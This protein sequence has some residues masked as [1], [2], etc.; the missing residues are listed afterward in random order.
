[1]AS[2]FVDEKISGADDLSVITRSSL[3]HDFTFNDF[4]TSVY[5]APDSG[6]QALVD[7]F[8]LWADSTTGIPYIE[9]TTAYFL[10]LD[11]SNPIVAIA[12]D[13]ND[14]NP[15]GPQFIPLSGTNLSYRPTNFESDA[16]LDYKFVVGGNW[17]LDPLNPH[18]CSGGFGPNS[19]LSMLA[20]RQPMEILNYEIPMGHMNTHAYTD[21][22]QG[23][24]RS[25]R[26]YTPPGYDGSESRYRN[27]YFLDGGEYLELGYAK[28][29]LDYMIF[30][31]L[32]PPVIAIFVDPSNRDVEYRY[33]LQFMD[34]FVQ[35]LVPW[36][37]SKYRTM[38]KA[39]D[40]AIVGVSLGGLTSL[41]FTL[42]HPQTFGNCGA[43]SPAIQLGDMIEQYQNSPVLPVKIYMDAGTY[44]ATI[45]NSATDLEQIFGENVWNYK[46]RVWHEGHSWGS[47]RAHVDE[48][49]AYFWPLVTTGVD[50][51][52]E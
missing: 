20:Y 43:Y 14:W 47:W 5:Q 3:Q 27:I 25:V 19:E 15:E 46:W 44:E 35:E 50:N 32:I 29:I 22:T 21:S 37:D 11:D 13:F 36:V 10:Y 4:I 6:K 38:A 8:V 30:N 41:L 23:K 12:G 2:E 18:T 49:L 17:I 31:E 39:S 51:R 24:T 42:H 33:D 48:S 1:M 26:V 40:R 16:R 7:A 9:D 34:M 28:N 45:Y 52:Y